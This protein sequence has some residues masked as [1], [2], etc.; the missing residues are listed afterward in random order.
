LA[1]AFQIIR[2]CAKQIGD[3]TTQVRHECHPFLTAHFRHVGMSPTEGCLSIGYVP[4]QDGYGLGQ[5]P[6][7]RVSSFAHGVDLATQAGHIIG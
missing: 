3:L 7:H 2:D 4:L 6:L 5:F 1:S